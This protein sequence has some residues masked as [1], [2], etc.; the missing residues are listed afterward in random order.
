MVHQ[1]GYGR[2]DE[3]MH[4]TR[5]HG[6]GMGPRQFSGNSYPILE[7]EEGDRRPVVESPTEILRSS[8]SSSP[9]GLPEKAAD[10]MDPYEDAPVSAAPQYRRPEP[11]RM[12]SRGFSSLF[13]FGTSP[14]LTLK[15]H[16]E[17][18]MTRG[19]AHRGTK[20]YPYRKGSGG[21]DKAVEVEERRGLV[22]ERAS[23][24]LGDAR[25]SIDDSPARPTVVEAARV[26][27]LPDLPR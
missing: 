13:H 20:D 11:P 8:P 24:D 22:E 17:D 23:E 6:P 7:E 19:G 9:H 18:N 3:A 16:T 12:P 1:Y 4:S 27:R 26:R 10:Y 5:A 25:P 21:D 14:D 15:P 2:N